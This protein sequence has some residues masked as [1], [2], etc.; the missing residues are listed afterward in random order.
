MGKAARNGVRRLGKGNG[1][2]IPGQVMLRVDPGAL[3]GMIAELAR[4][5]VL[6]TGSNG[7][8]TT[9]R[10]LAQIMRAGGLHP[11]LNGEGSNQLSGLATTMVA[12]AAPTGRLRQDFRAIGLFE[13]DEGSFPEVMPHIRH[14]AAIVVTNLFRD[15]LDRYFEPAYIMG[16]LE[17][18]MR[19]LPPDTTLILNADDP[20]I[21]CLAAD[22]P[23]PRLYFG[24]ADTGPCRSEPDPTSDCPRCPRCGGEL[25]YSSVFYA[26]LGHWACPGCGLARPEPDIRATGIELIGSQSTRLEIAT[27]AATTVISVPLPG[28]YN[29]YNALAAV[30]A[31]TQCQL[32]EESLQAIGEITAGSY[33]MERVE[34]DGRDVYLALAK[35]ANGYTEVLRAVLGDGLPKR[36][37]LGLNTNPGKQPDTSWIWDVDFD[38][39][40]GL[41]LVPVVSGNRAADLAV[42]LKY[43]GWPDPG[44]VIVQPDPVAAFQ[45]ALA[46]TPPGQPLWIVSTSVVLSG[47]RAWLRRHGYVRELW[48]EFAREQQEQARRP[49]LRIRPQAPALPASVQPRP[50]RRP[51]A[52]P[53]QTVELPAADMPSAGPVRPLVA[54]STV[55]MPTTADLPPLIAEGD[56]PAAPAG[57]EASIEDRGAGL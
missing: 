4:G 42:R 11:V 43:A 23:N 10:M 17:R 41:V 51:K 56:D 1:T 40:A 32:P 50:V 25:S 12:H 3:G 45:A 2:A 54:G 5:C 53:L 55:S 24:M 16:L 18:T 37:L 30:A 46:A 8:G 13:V 7:K 38:A 29:A 21:A 52:L 47:I 20:R 57:R 19:S 36:M 39:I 35:N 48:Q 33:R 49:R 27:P 9:C 6:V 28:L 26:H 14:P 31:A 15:Q 22:L 34:V 44:D